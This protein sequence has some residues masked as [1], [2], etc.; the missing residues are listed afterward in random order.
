MVKLGGS[1]ITDKSEYRAFDAP[2]VAMLCKEIKDSGKDVI[3]VHGAGSFGHILAKEHG[4]NDGHRDESQIPAV[5]EICRDVREL[6]NMV[7]SKL[8]GA[9]LPAVGIPPGSCFI[10][11]NRKLN[12]RDPEVLRRFVGQIGRASCRERV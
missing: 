10:M 6:N 11:E 8:I 7:V 3:V 9:G 2:G 1:V 12:L 5:A 4:I